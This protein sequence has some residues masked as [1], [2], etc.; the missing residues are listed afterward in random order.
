MARQL[1]RTLT[2][3][4]STYKLVVVFDVPYLQKKFVLNMYRMFSF[5]SFLNKYGITAGRHDLSSC[6]MCGI[7]GGEQGIGRS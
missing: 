2:W 3:L 7:E 6:D 1:Y 4:G 5:S